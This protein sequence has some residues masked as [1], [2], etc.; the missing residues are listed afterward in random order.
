M[1]G[2]VASLGLIIGL[3]HLPLQSPPHRVGWFTQPSPDQIVLS[4][5]VPERPTEESAPERPDKA[6]PPTEL[7]SSRSTQTAHTSPSRE[8]ETD[9]PQNDPETPSKQASERTEVRSV[10]TL[11][12]MDRKPQIAGGMGSLY[13]HIHY[14]EK[15]RQQGIEGLLELEFIIETDG[16]VRDIEVVDSLHP[17][18]DSAAVEGV[19][20]VD[21]V[22]AKRDGTPIPVRLR[23]PVRFELAAMS[24]RM[25]QDTPNR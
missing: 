7:R 23:L 19:R 5:V 1:L 24:S 10:A 11:G 2:L 18:C 4:D 16:T 21:F 8:S 14:P 3:V 13:L 22:P 20:S 6:P 9:P 17:L 15:A 25:Q 12:T